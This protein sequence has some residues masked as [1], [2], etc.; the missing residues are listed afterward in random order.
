MAASVD[1][2]AY[3]ARIGYPGPSE[4]TLAVLQ[5]LA[6]RHLSVI[7]FENLDPLL[8]HPVDLDPAA[9]VT[10][11]VRGRRG[12]YCQEHNSLFHDVLAALGF[13]VVALGGRVLWT[14]DEGQ[15]APL[16][17]RLTLVEFPEGKFI[18][19]VGFGGPCPT[20]PLCLEP[21]VEQTTPYGTYR[22]RRDGKASELQLQVN[23]RWQA[24][25]RFDLAAQS[26]ADFEVANWYTSTH[27][28]SLFTQYL[29]A[30]RI[31]G[32]TRVNLLNANLSV[33]QPDGRV[34]HRRLA[35]PGELEKV[36]EEVMGPAAHGGRNH[37]GEAA[38]TALV[39]PGSTCDQLTT[40][41]V[42]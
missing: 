19:D 14:R 34:E 28:R 25:Y 41:E 15:P 13:S 31:V 12:G 39:P 4:P 40:Q 18:A 27:P 8:G 23:D 17:H 37:L 35:G 30:C 33:R 24:M 11:L 32:Q 42:V 3:F 29:V 5:E 36:L 22:F 9:I 10:K 38:A 1:L 21:G 26:R 20:T 6:A 7:A 16:T 2:P